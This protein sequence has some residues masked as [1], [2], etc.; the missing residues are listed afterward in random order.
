MQKKHSVSMILGAALVMTSVAPVMAQEAGDVFVRIAAGRSKLAD[1]GEVQMAGAVV[2]G[3]DY[4]TRATYHNTLGLGYFIADHIAIEGSVSTPVTTNNNPA[5]SIGMFPNL[6]DDEFMMATLGASLHPF[7]GPVSP[8]IGGGVQTMQVTRTRDRLADGFK[9]KNAYGPYALAGVDVALNKRFGLYVEGRKAFYHTIAT[10]F[11]PM[12]GGV[13]APLRAKAELDPF[14]INIGLKAKFGPSTDKEN[15][16]EIT[17]DTSRW[18][19]RLGFSTLNLANKID[20]SSAGV[21]GAALSTYEHHTATAQLGYFVTPNVAINATVGVPPTIDIFGANAV[22]EVPQLGR[23]TYGPTS[24]TLQY[25]PTRDGR[26]RPYVGA[27]LS[28]MFVFAEKDGA[29]QNLKVD[30]DLGFALEAGSEL[31]IANK[32][33]LFIEAKKAFL[34]PKAYGTFGGAEVEGKTKLDP[35]VFSGGVSFHF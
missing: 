4:T 10:G 8:Y 28:Y 30:E 14:T 15:E 1:K 27:G 20:L 5:G 18:V 17:T 11:L 22:G 35:W 29:F 19:V 25:H 7:K 16:E 3:A 34:R 31:M 24:L 21:N 32:T 13:S 9:A 33:A 2:P 6:A 12:G 26:V 23:I